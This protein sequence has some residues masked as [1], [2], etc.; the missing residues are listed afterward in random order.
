M[1]RF[2]LTAAMVVAMCGSMVGT[3]SAAQARRAPAGNKF[4]RDKA[5]IVERPA[6]WIRRPGSDSAS[7][8]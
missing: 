1:R 4:A 3:A 5:R 8:S 2:M 7:W 6:G